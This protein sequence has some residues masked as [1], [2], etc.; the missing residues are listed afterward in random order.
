MRL[1]PSPMRPSALQKCAFG[2]TDWQRRSICNLTNEG[3]PAALLFIAGAASSV[4]PKAHPKAEGRL[5]VQA[6]AASVANQGRRADSSLLKERTKKGLH[7][8]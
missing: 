3:F 6:T 5:S 1:S 2:F 8:T 7:L 4:K